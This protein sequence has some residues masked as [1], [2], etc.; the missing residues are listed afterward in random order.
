MADA[1]ALNALILLDRS[2]SMESRWAEALGAVNAYVK[3]LGEADVTLATFDAVDGL[4]FE[5]IRDRVAATAWKDVTS[6]EATPRGQTPLYD[7]F[8]R[9]VALADAAGREKTV[10]IVMTDG[11]EN[12]SREVSAKDA[13]A[14]VERCKSKGWQV[15]F[16]GADFDAFAEADQIGVKASATLSVRS[17]RYGAAFER[18]ARH[19]RAYADADLS[20][21]SSMEFTDEDRREAAGE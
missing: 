15:V 5:V 2:G 7:A 17:G 8:A 14:M 9:I 19:T 13:R 20:E 21:L 6:A 10:V 3:E 1:V 11:A 4:K 12:A 18:L 16:L